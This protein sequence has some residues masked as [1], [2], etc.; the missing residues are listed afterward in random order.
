MKHGTKYDRIAHL[1]NIL[2]WPFEHYLFNYWRKEFITQLEGKILDVGIG[3]GNNIGYYPHNSEIVGIDLSKKMLK[4]SRNVDTP[5]KVNLILMDAQ[6][7][8]FED[9]SFDYVVSTFVMCNIYKPHLALK[10]L[11]RVCKPGGLIINIEHLRS[12]TKSISFIQDL[13]NPFTKYLLGEYINRDIV[14]FI[15]SSGL[16]VIETKNLKFKDVFKLIISRNID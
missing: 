1:Y 3:T 11:R 5:N 8:G 15:Q 9:N 2:E 6:M 14:Y 4:Y 16:E 10:E 12:E 7:L 13:F